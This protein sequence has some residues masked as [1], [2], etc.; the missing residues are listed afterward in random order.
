MRN[1]Q[2]SFFI[3]LLF[4]AFADGAAAQCEV[5]VNPTS[6]S[7]FDVFDEAPCAGDSVSFEG[8]Q[9]WKSEAY[10]LP[11]LTQGS[12]YAV[13]L[14]AIF[15]TLEW[16]PDFTVI[17]PSGAVDAFGSDAESPCSLEFVASESGDYLL[18]VNEENNCGTA[19]NLANG[20]LT[21]I[22]LQ[23]TIDCG[24]PPSFIA[25]AESFESGDIPTC[26]IEIDADGDGFGWQVS[27]G[28]DAFDGSALIRSVSFSSATGALMPDNFLITP[29][30]AVQDGDSLY[31][32]VRST[33]V[34]FSEQ[35]EIR[36]STS[37]TEPENFSEVLLL[38][39]ILRSSWSGRSIDL[40]AYAGDS[41]YIAFRH[42]NSIGQAAVLIDAVALLGA[43]DCTPLSIYGS[44]G[45]KDLNIYPNPSQ[46]VLNL[47]ID[48]PVSAYSVE[49][50]DLQGRVV[51]SANGVGGNGLPESLDFSA[52]PA[53][54]Y[55]L[56]LHHGSNTG[57]SKV[58][59]K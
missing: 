8:F 50:I 15:E 14:C 19:E 34:E 41:I 17:A 36:V 32:V 55:L 6:T 24:P 47:A 43:L 29:E 28:F 49:L 33:D 23:S 44:A 2:N 39:D 26:W 48:G 13:T 40:S 35:Y 56:K 53:G 12:T 22:T 58:V 42:G 18:A 59:L 30:L 4:M 37:G 46:G 1:I 38:D 7:G 27:G 57:I 5:W 20:F 21:L 51:L 11:E 16:N 52:A 3:A 45:Q 9:V 31:Y 10:V 54:I 25:G